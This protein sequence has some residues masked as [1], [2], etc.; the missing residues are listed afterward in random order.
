MKLL[1]K[2]ILSLILACVLCIAVAIPTFASTNV[3]DQLS[4]ADNEITAIVVD[5]EE[6]LQRV[7]EEQ[8]QISPRAAFV[9]CFLARNGNTKDC[10]VY[11]KWSGGS[12]YDGWRFKKLT[13]TNFSVT[14]PV[15]Y[16][17]I[18]PP[19]GTTYKTYNVNSASTGTVKLGDVKVPTSVDEVKCKFDSLQGSLSANNDWLSVAI[20]STTPIN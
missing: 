14:K 17:T 4:N 9:G 5:S 10:E 6:E 12:R 3:E 2:R 1:G 18:K 11:L 19:A 13:I 8:Q 7:I 15:T 16:G 20:T